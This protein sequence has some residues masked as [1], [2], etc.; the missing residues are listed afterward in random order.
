MAIYGFMPSFHDAHVLSIR[1]VGRDL[2]IKLYVYDL[3]GGIQ[4]PTAKDDRHCVAELIWKD[5]RKA[6]LF[7][8]DNWLNDVEF[9]E[10]P[11]ELVTKLHDMESGQVGVIEAASVSVASLETPV[12]E[13][14]APGISS[15]K[16]V[17]VSLFG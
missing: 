16:T 17:R 1:R 13:F 15:I 4:N 5:V 6:E 3:P 8:T 12:E 11:N 10:S 9:F 2:C 7:I 14:K